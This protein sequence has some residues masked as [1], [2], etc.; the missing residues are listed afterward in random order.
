M[1][2]TPSEVFRF[3]ALRPV[4]LATER[5]T[6]VAVIRD[7]RAATGDGLKQLAAFAQTI[8]SPGRARRRWA[9]VDLTPFAALAAARLLLLEDYAGLDPHVAAPPAAQFVTSAGLD[10][11]DP[12][13]DGLWD[14]LWD[15]LYIAHATGPDAGS[16]LDVPTAALRALYFVALVAQ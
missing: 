9:Q 5:E 3:D 10:E 14:R 8:S 11:V 12:A 15:I 13:D 4:Q 1:T 7:R 6:E 16:L 2:V